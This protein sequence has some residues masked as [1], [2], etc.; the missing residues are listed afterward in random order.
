ME[1]KTHILLLIVGLALAFT[2]MRTVHTPE[3]M[4]TPGTTIQA[5]E[6]VANDCFACHTPFA[7]ATADKCIDCHKVDEIGLMTTKGVS[8]AKEKKN[9]RFHQQL[10]ESDCVACHSDHKGVQPFRPISRFSH[11]LL[12]SELQKQCNS[13]HNKPKDSLH[14][15][16]KAECSQCH[17]QK[18]WKPATFRHRS[19][20]PAE[21]KQ[22]ESCHDKPK[23][24][25]HRKFKS[26]C[27]VCHGY[28]DW[29]ATHFKHSKLPP[30]ELKQC[31][32]CHDKPRDDKHRKFK[33]NCDSC[34]GYND[35][36]D[37]D[38]KHSKLPPAEL[39]Q[40]QSCHEKP[41]DSL[42]GSTKLECGECH[43]QEK[44]KPATFNHSKYFRF[45]RHHRT[46][47]DTCHVNN[48]YAEY[49]C[50]G[51]HEHSRSNIRSEHMEEGIRDY[52]NCTECH[53]S[54]NEHEAKRA[55]R[56][57][58][59]GGGTNYNFSGEHEWGEHEHEDD[60]D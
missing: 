27:N 4:I 7:G 36:D 5:H 35:W 18:E 3:L 13:C 58:R 59:Y 52:E 48:D 39:K 46:D 37:V 43:G 56:A 42:H 29:E 49:T 8:I 44:W 31:E 28:D 17:T 21:L 53:R 45:D 6:E 25:K 40:C 50:Y 20:D 22:C 12:K 24:K 51:C 30:A 54:A 2:L 60:D 14:R 15:K 55:W 33:G 9:V 11:N 23:D 10:V 47:C 57:K 19:L 1:M 26:N 32:S 38:F 34:H 41:D 16:L